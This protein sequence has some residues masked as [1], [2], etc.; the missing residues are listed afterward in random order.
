[1]TIYPP[2]I[3]RPISEDNLGGWRNSTRGIILHTSA[4]D[5]DGEAHQRF[6]SSGYR[7]TSCNFYIDK[8]GTVSQYADADRV[9][10]ATG[11]ANSTTISVET[12][13]QGDEPWEPAQVLA[14]RDICVWASETYGFPMQL[15]S[16]SDP[17][18]SGIGWHRLGVPATYAQ[19]NAGISQTGGE[20]WSPDIGKVCP[21]D[22]RIEQI[23]SLLNLSSI[24]QNETEEDTMIIVQRGNAEAIL[25]TS[26]GHWSYIHTADAKMNL[27]S[28]GIKAASVDDQTFS[29]LMSPNLKLG[30]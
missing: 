19:V 1:M 27:I 10:W 29:G 25:L 6:W 3:Q 5:A 17:G 14:I 15:M 28:A 4:S 2:A 24:S 13:G 7:G 18:E 30:G 20:S 23:P 22:L 16:S 11:A 21:G 12:Q 8:D 26:T 9:T